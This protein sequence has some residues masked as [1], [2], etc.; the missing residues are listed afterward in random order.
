MN[1]D[2]YTVQP[3]RW[4]KLWELHISG[5]HCDGVTQT[6]NLDFAE[7]IARDYISLVR[8]VAP[9]SFDVIITPEVDCSR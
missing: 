9:N 5:P 7:C 2:T 4:R 6:T 1:R 8:E 3:K